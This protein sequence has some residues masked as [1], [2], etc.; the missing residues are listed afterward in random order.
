M[1]CLNVNQ[2]S[3]NVTKY[4]GG[5]QCS[6]AEDSSLVTSFLFF[7]YFCYKNGTSELVFYQVLVDYLLKISIQ[8]SVQLTFAFTC[9]QSYLNQIV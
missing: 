8:P 2:P 5:L 7:F 9:L 4:L 6:R 1:C 3:G